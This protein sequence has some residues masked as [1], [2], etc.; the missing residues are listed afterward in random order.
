MTVCS[1]WDKV[2]LT[3]TNSMELMKRKRVKCLKCYKYGYFTQI[4]PLAAAVS[5]KKHQ[6]TIIIY[7]SQRCLYFLI[8]V[9]LPLISSHM[10]HSDGETRPI[11]V[12]HHH[13]HHHQQ[14]QQRQ[15]HQQRPQLHIRRRRQCLSHLA[16]IN[17][18]GGTK[19]QETRRHSHHHHHHQHQFINLQHFLST[20]CLATWKRG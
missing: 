5:C 18:G 20:T 4:R 3:P 12:H 9:L 10:C 11:G 13:H 8:L 7:D 1:T 2:K 16:E 19:P 15:E 14:H 17:G 6:S